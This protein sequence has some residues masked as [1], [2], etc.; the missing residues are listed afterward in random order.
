MEGAPVRDPGAPAGPLPYGPA[1]APSR[2]A[3]DDD[4]PHPPG[5]VPGEV[6][7]AGGRAVG[8]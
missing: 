7:I 3:G 5:Q 8:L 2:G 6:S 1:S 4:D